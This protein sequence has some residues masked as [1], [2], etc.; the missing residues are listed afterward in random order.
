[1]SAVIFLGSYLPLA[2]ILLAQDFEYQFLGRGFCWRIWGE[3]PPCVVPL[4]HSRLSL[5]LVGICSISFALSLAA[6]AFSK[7]KPLVDVKQARYIPAELMNYTLP[8][9]VAFMGIGYEETGKL[10]GLAIFLVWMFWI[11]QKSGQIILN[12]V[13]VVFGW[14]LY[15]IEYVFVGDTTVKNGRALAKSIVEPGGRYR[16][17]EVQ[18]IVILRAV[19]SQRRG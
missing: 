18:D 11:T 6:L 15:E 8:Y 1:M 5:A 4:A 12:P 7:S 3:N 14:R 2:V 19:H 17:V 13:L 9:I 10:V 16:H